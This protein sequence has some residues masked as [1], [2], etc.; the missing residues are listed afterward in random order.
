MP[1]ADAKSSRVAGVVR[2]DGH[3]VGE[4]DPNTSESA[5][6]SANVSRAVPKSNILGHRFG[7]VAL[8]T[9][10]FDVTKA[11]ERSPSGPPPVPSDPLRTTATT[12][13]TGELPQ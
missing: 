9:T 5:P 10:W 13:Y 7:F 2:G 3:A 6:S 4:F 12:A 11:N 8:T 1:S